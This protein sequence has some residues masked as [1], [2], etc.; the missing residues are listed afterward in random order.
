VVLGGGLVEAMPDLYVGEVKR[1]LA[2]SVMPSLLPLTKVTAAALADDATVMG[3]AKWSE[4]ISSSQK[5]N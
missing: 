3:A 4:I 1:A 5:G 2:T